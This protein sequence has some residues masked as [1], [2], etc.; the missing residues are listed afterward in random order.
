MYIHTC[1]GNDTKGDEGVAE[2]NFYSCFLLKFWVKTFKLNISLGNF[3]TAG[4]LFFKDPSQLPG[5]IAISPFLGGPKSNILIKILRIKV[6]ILAACKP[7]F[8]CCFV[9]WQNYHI[10]CITFENF[11]VPVNYQDF[12]E[13]DPSFV[14]AQQICDNE[15]QG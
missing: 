8:K 9:N 14:I 3:L 6:W 7:L 5:I 11:S 13:K 2:Y 1:V 10:I 15:G 12:Q 4:H